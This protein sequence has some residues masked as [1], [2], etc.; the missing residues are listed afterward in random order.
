MNILISS[1]TSTGTGI[2]KTSYEALIFKTTVNGNEP[3][4]DGVPTIEKQPKV[5]PS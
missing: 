2:P 4:V 5:P 3:R 1:E